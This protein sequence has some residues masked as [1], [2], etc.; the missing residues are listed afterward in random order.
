MHDI[1]YAPPSPARG[2]PGRGPFNVLDAV[3]FFIFQAQTGFPLL[4]TLLGLQPRFGDN[5]LKF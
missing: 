5:P 4:L 1:E 2:N 3:T